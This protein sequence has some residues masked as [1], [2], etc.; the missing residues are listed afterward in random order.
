MQRGNNEDLPMCVLVVENNLADRE[1]LVRILGETHRSIRVSAVGDGDEALA[2]LDK[3]CRGEFPVPNLILLDLG[4]TK[5]SGREAL[6]AIKADLR[7]KSIPVVVL[8][9]SILEG[10][11]ANCYELGAAT[12]VRKPAAFPDFVKVATRIR[13]YWL[14]AAVLPGPARER[15]ETLR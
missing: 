5:L 4:L 2:L 14:E 9:G 8:T 13:D 7:L 1:L 3:A 11:V 6:R 12:F 15:E 10:D